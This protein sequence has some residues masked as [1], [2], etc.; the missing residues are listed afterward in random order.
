MSAAIYLPGLKFLEQAEDKLA[1]LI[2]A[3]ATSA[4]RRIWS[5]RRTA[6]RSYF[7]NIDRRCSY[8]RTIVDPSYNLT[9]EEAYVAPSFHHRKTKYS[10]IDVWNYLKSNHRV[11][12]SGTGGSGK[13]IFLKRVWTLAREHINF[14]APIFYDLRSVNDKEEVD[15][16]KLLFRSIFPDGNV[17][18]FIAFHRAISNGTF[19]FILDAFDEVIHSKRRWLSDEIQRLCNASQDN[20]ILMSTRYDQI[21]SSW[22]DFPVFTVDPFDDDQVREFVGKSKFDEEIKQKFLKQHDSGKFAKQKSFLEV[23][24]LCM[25]M[26]LTFEQF[27]EIPQKL[28]LFYSKV[29]EVLY[30]RHDAAK[31]A[32]KR[33]HVSRLDED[34]FKGVFSF[35][36]LLSYLDGN[37][38]FSDDDL[39][40]Y[41][42][43][44]AD[45]QNVE[46]NCAAYIEDLDQGVCLVQRDGI[47]NKFSHR[48]FQE[49]FS[50]YCLAF[51][52][53]EKM[54]DLIHHLL[55][56]TNDTSFAMLRDMAQEAV[57]ST[58][59]IPTLTTFVN[60]FSGIDRRSG[61]WYEEFIEQFGLEV[62]LTQN[63]GGKSGKKQTTLTARTDSPTPVHQIW[64]YFM[65]VDES[66]H[67][68]RQVGLR[69]E[70]AYDQ[71]E[72]LSLFINDRIIPA[73]SNS[74]KNNNEDQVNGKTIDK[75]AIKEIGKEEFFDA[76]S[77]TKIA[78]VM[79]EDFEY[80]S[81]KLKEIAEQSKSR[82]NVLDKLLAK[83]TERPSRSGRRKK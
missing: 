68:S 80:L 35:L 19:F 24:L 48:S 31:G 20:M 75:N 34:N 69:G 4:V 27:A 43:N 49:Y 76:F 36:S 11:V 51:K 63:S 67:M 28:H 82:S 18:D 56:R 60:S 44:S 59:T 66:R 47:L 2:F 72:S 26:I 70:A 14:K 81:G 58:L 39:A 83:R 54:P 42:R 3:G 55:A 13:T 37:I 5:E 62:A 41:I 16:R 46:V 15:F 74:K 12:V 57:D 32:Y 7:L 50:A 25:M 17:D 61:R 8:I 64:N 77:H 73:I 78:Q 6:Y 21:I 45:M 1:S 29:F 22:Q 71:S 33:E 79:V 53:R 40:Q 38:E 9:L 52:I 23:P 10:D 30:S 65:S